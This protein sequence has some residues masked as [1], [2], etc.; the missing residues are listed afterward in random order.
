M[1]AGNG[2]SDDNSDHRYL[3][4]LAPPSL[5]TQIADAVGAMPTAQAH[6]NYRLLAD[7]TAWTRA[8]DELR[9]FDPQRYLAIL[10]VVEDIC[11]IHRDPLAPVEATGHFVFPKKKQGVL[12]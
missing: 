1:G 4:E 3:D 9:R 10:K 6:T 11:S 5:R 7:D 2:N 12:D 8:G